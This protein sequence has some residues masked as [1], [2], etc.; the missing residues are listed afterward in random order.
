MTEEDFERACRQ[1]ISAGFTVSEAKYEEQIFGS[2]YIEAVRSDLPAQQLVWDGKDGWLIV[3][4]QS[5]AGDWVD[6]WIGRKLEQHSIE[7]A[8]AQMETPPA[9]GDGGIDPGSS[10]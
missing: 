8:L 3:L 6:R 9:N 1:L 2:W 7:L 10:A 5:P 4:T